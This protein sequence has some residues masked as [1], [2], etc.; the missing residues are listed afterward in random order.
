MPA[1]CIIDYILNI[2]IMINIII[3]IIYS[4]VSPYSQDQHCDYTT[5]LDFMAITTIAF[6]VMSSPTR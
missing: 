4:H 2:I 3:I 6:L 1:A 5:L